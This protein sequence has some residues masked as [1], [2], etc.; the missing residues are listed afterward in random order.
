MIIIDGN[1]IAA[2][3]MYGT[4]YKAPRLD[5]GL[6]FDALIKSLIRHLGIL[7]AEKATGPVI[8][9]VD[10]PSWR[11]KHLKNYKGNR[12]D[13]HKSPLYREYKDAYFDLAAEMKSCLPWRIVKR[14]DMEADDLLAWYALND[15]LRNTPRVLISGDKDIVACIGGTVRLYDMNKEKFWEV[16]DPRK[17]LHA[18]IC[19]G[20]ASDNIPSIV[21]RKSNGQPKIRFGE[22]TA[23][24]KYAKMDQCYIDEKF[25]ADKVKKHA[26]DVKNGQRLPEDAFTEQDCELM[27]RNY[28]SNRKLID[29]RYSPVHYLKDLPITS[30]PYSEENIA[31]FMRRHAKEYYEK[32]QPRVNA[33]LKV[34]CG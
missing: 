26:N 11:Y 16:E 24:T 12:T 10:S 7:H 31:I 15:T 2:K 32:N 29:L 5:R 30:R 34:L 21:P 8:F 22:K 18:L 14:K 19:A 23:L 27:Y 9:C 28:E 1:S 25:L 13:Q 17:F 6:Y 20:D 4:H 33:L 3:V